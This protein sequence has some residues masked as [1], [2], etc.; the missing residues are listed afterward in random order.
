M[1]KTIRYH[2]VNGD[3]SEPVALEKELQNSKELEQLRRDL[4]QK[5]HCFKTVKFPGQPDEI[6]RVKEIIID[7]YV[8]VPENFAIALK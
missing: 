4:E 7:F 1:I 8:N 2:V 6:K 5:H 3:K